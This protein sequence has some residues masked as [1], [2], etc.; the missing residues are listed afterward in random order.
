MLY[1]HCSLEEINQLAMY[2]TQFNGTEPGAS[3]DAGA[4]IR[5]KK[6]L[7][8]VQEPQPAEVTGFEYREECTAIFVQDAVEPSSLLNGGYQ[9]ARVRNKV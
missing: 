3:L 8:L 7:D 4:R 2:C 6:G 9:E 5:R 1:N